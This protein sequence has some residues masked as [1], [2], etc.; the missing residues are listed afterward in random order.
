[1]SKLSSSK[2]FSTKVLPTSPTLSAAAQ[3]RQFPQRS[4]LPL[5]PD[6]VWKIEMGIVRTMTWLEDGTMMTLGLWGPGD[7][8]GKPLSRVEPYQVECLTKVEAVATTLEDWQQTAE[9][10]SA[11]ARQSEELLIIRSYKRTE[12]MLIKLLEWLAKRFGRNIDKGQL[13]DLRLTHQ[14]ISE[15]L[16]STR[17]TVTRTLIQF[18]QQG[19]IERLP[20]HRI[21]LR[22]EEF[23]H[24]EI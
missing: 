7:M 21:V 5:K 13:I 6:S 16:G 20:L 17:V 22:E 23:W 10:M 12:V 19:V 1:M 15:I 4:Q 3:R 24:Y 9:I 18:E 14:D 2:L 8:V 11:Y